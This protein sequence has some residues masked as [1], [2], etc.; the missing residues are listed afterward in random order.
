MPRVLSTSDFLN[1][2]KEER[3]PIVDVRAPKEYLKGH[4]PGAVNV[5]LFED[6]ERHI[7][8]IQYKEQGK[9]QA[10]LKG[11]ELVGPKLAQFVLQAKRLS[12]SRELLVHCWRGGMRSQSLAWLWETSGFEVGVLNGGYKAYR[13]RVRSDLAQ[14][15]QLII[16]GGKT[17]SGKT[18]LLQALEDVGEQ[19]IDLESIANHKGS[20]F[21]GIGQIAQPSVEQ[22][23]NELH[24]IVQKLDH[25]RRIWVEDESNAIGRVY[26]PQEFW[27]QMQ[28]APV[29]V[30]EVPHEERIGRL[31]REY[32]GCEDQELKAAL[33]RIKKRLGGKDLGLALEA[34]E[35]KDYAL[36][37]EIALRYYDKAY[38]FSL[39]RKHTQQLY[40]ITL[41]LQ[42]L[43][44][45]SQQ[46]LEYCQTHISLH[47]RFGYDQADAI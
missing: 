30:V 38:S 27:K 42:N 7:I 40:T 2:N 28:R 14:P 5:P 18:A 4:I 6:E 47:D 1:Q 31:V 45:S 25:T 20:A 26:I 21:G 10:V 35:Q 41:S 22:F 9:E 32:A 17:G 46:L 44:R 34:L 3:T 11:L 13:R 12:A 43:E 23:E 8:G 16:L 24:S 39:K 33:I 37:A 19:V 15:L 36:T 29:V